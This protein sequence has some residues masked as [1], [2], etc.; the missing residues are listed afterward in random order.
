MTALDDDDDDLPQRIREA[1]AWDEFCE[2]LRERN[3]Y[4]TGD[5]YVGGLIEDCEKC[6][7]TIDRGTQLYRARIM[8]LNREL[9]HKPLSLNEMLPPPPER[10]TGGRLNPEGIPYFY[11]ALETD[12]AIAEVRPWRDAQVTVAVFETTTSLSVVDLSG[13]NGPKPTMRADW[14]GYMMSRP[15]H[16]QDRWGYLGTQFLAEQLKGRG[17]NGIIY[18]SALQDGGLNVALFNADRARGRSV[19]LYLVGAVEYTTIDVGSL[20][21]TNNLS[22]E[23]PST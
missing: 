16:Q 18:G 6:V 19:S 17:H 7:T 20:R 5:D 21:T 11:C 23:G 13:V 10:A 12:T 15:V 3:R 22:N 4:V 1:V 8:P 14:L 2:G 9:D